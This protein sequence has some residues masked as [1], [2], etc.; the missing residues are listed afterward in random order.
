M[1]R[2]DRG[3]LG[4]VPGG[5]VARAAWQKITMLTSVRGKVSI[6]QNF[7][8]G[9]GSVIS[10][11]HGLVIGTS[12]SV[13]RNC[14]IEASGIIGDKTVIAALVGIVGRADH[15]IDE[16]G[17]AVIDS[18]WVGDRPVTDLDR[19]EIGEDVWI[20]YGA[21]V[22]SGIRVGN[23]A[24]IAAGAVVVHDVPDFAIVAGN[25]ARVVSTRFDFAQG[26]E[27]LAQLRDASGKVR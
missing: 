13:G 17:H 18:T 2:R 1:T 16:V 25:P 7:R 21:T 27:H 4:N 6:G 22:V 3:R 11:Q 19:V 9:S 20:G 24:V 10:S 26:S 5:T 23:G 8:L 12:V 15:A 14:T